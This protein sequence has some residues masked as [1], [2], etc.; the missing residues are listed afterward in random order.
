MRLQKSAADGYQEASDG[1]MQL[2]V[3]VQCPQCRHKYQC[4]QYGPD[5]IIHAVLVLRKASAVEAKLLKVMDSELSATELNNKHSFLKETSLEE[6]Q[7]SCQRLQV[8]FNEIGFISQLVQPLD[9]DAWRPHVC[10]LRSQ[11]RCSPRNEAR[12]SK[13]FRD[14]TLFLG[15]DELMTS[16]EQEFVT[17]L[18]IS[19]KVDCLS[20]AAHILN[21]VLDMAASRTIENLSLFQSN[22]AT[23]S[24]R[25]ATNL[26]TMHR[27]R[28]EYPLP[29]RM[30]RCVRLETY[31]PSLRSQRLLMFDTK[32]DGLV[33][34]NI[35]GV[36][37]RLGLRKGDVVTHVN[38]EPVITQDDY[39]QALQQLQGEG[40][41]WLI[42]NADDDT[43]A[44]LAERGQLM[45]AKGVT[46]H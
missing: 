4:K 3:L 21:G 34:I 2:R 24:S 36:A 28:K 38:G 7:D 16:E 20:Q 43:A 44:K 13:P 45:R 17:S 22:A 15:L 40:S 12:D 27:V 31:D 33:L 35:R 26:Q 29:A 8:Y 18:L 5:I 6:L 32:S 25:P 46:F 19:G 41:F 11:R 39:H 14:P 30:P 37:G 1:S 42:V 10:E 23:R 9:W